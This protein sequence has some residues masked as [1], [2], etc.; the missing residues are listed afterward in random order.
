[1]NINDLSSKQL[2]D[3]ARSFQTKKRLG[4]NFLVDASALQ[5]IVDSLEL[6]AGNRVI[7][8]GPGIGFL[9]RLLSNQ[10]VDVA[11]VELDRDCI[12]ALKELNLPGV[13][14]RHGDFLQYDLL[15][16]RFV[17]NTSEKTET[18]TQEQQLKII[19]NVPYQITGL[20]LH[21]VLGEI[22]EPSPWL[23]NIDRIVLTVQRE[24]ALR[25]VAQAGS[26]HYSQVSLHTRYFCQADLVSLIEPDSFYPKPEVTSAIIRLTPHKTPL[27]DCKDE[28]LLRRVIKAGFAQRR[29]MLRKALTSLNLGSLDIDALF[30]EKTID[31]QSRAEN[32]SLQQFAMLTNAIHDRLNCNADDKSSLS[33]QA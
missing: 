11:A 33:C 30:R 26:E 19:G 4:Q 27:V 2:H 1:M 10:A 20:I 5:L 15:A 22:G 29:K 3:A 14:L 21:H 13:V 24:V 6:K 9:T 8:I 28:K 31:P 17:T 12:E 25:M 18:A 7:E 23:P 16:D 32:L